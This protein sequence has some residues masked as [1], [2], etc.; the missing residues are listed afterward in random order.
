MLNELHIENLAVIENA[1]I[2]LQNNLN[3]FTGETGA[4]KSVLIGGINAILGQRVYKDV[5]RA[6]TDK[7]YVSA[8]FTELP[9]AVTKKLGEL[10]IPC[11][12]DELILSREI[13]SDG[14]SFAKIN[15]R[16]VTASALKDIGNL[17]VNIH[18]QHDSQVLLDAS[19][20]LDILDNYAGSEK[21]I[22][23]YQS[24]FRELQKTAREINKL[25]ISSKISAQRQM[26]LNQIVL[27]IGSLEISEDEDKLVEQRFKIA[28]NAVSLSEAMRAALSC[29]NSDESYGAGE[30]VANAYAELSVHEDVMKELEPITSRLNSVIIEINDIAGELSH[31]L[32]SL[33]IDEAEYDRLTQRRAQLASIKKRYGPEL[34]DAIKMYE[35]AL[36]EIKKFESSDE[37]ISEL[38]SKKSELLVQVTKKAE[39]LSEFRLKA[40][41]KFVGEVGSELSF[42]N[43]PDVV[44]SVKHEKGKLTLSGMDNIEFLISANRGEEPKPLAKI[45]SGGELS[46]IMLALKAVLAD[47]D[48]IPTLIFD[49]IDAG[50]S[51]RAAQKIGIKLK[52]ISSKHQVICVTH[53]PQIAIMANNHL[54]IEKTVKG[55]RTVTDVKSLN[56][57]ERVHEIARFLGGNNI[58]E[59]VLKDAEEQLKSTMEVK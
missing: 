24:S 51:G 12:D 49:E 46:R 58:T 5:V 15:S 50:V 37:A 31:L 52:E 7:A 26:Y 53:L 23:D 44:L 41:Q 6:G 3:V 21:L 10:D 55:D 27:D 39:A 43:M 30:L 35:S 40:S 2:E 9:D 8:V 54:L 59:T 47:K 29:L 22:S 19:K 14:K 25:K 11:E 36:D 38:E 4:G 45:A 13:R 28:D 32:D 16:P 57:D 33:D 1:T 34:S 20:H 56:F 18:G 48:A 17:L 42:L